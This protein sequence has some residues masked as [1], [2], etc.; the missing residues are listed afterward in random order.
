MFKA[1]GI[2]LQ[3]IQEGKWSV[4]SCVCVFL[5][6][7]MYSQ[8]PRFQLP[9]VRSHNQGV[10]IIAVWDNIDLDSSTRYLSL[11]IFSNFL[12]LDL[13]KDKKIFLR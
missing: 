5:F 2:F 11:L 7:V 13:L 6:G 3:K 9:A 10:R 8:G 4:G 12:T 1:L